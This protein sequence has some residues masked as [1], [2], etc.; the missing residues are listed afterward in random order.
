MICEKLPETK[1]EIIAQLA[2][3][4]VVGIRDTAL[5]MTGVAKQGCWNEQEVTKEYIVKIQPMIIEILDELK[6]Q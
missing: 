1:E 3:N 5:F 6:E 4:K 2:K